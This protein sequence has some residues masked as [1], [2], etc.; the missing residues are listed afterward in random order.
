MEM[1]QI[2]ELLKKMEANRKT[3][4]EEMEAK[5]RADKEDFMARMDANMKAWQEKA[6]ADT[7]AWGEEIRSMRFETTN[8]RTET[9]ACQEVE[10]RQEEKEPSSVDMKPEVGEQREVP[11]ED[12]ELMP[13]GEPKK[14]RRRDRKLVAERRR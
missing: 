8:T 5:R 3:D 1:Q 13:V 14:K 2:M 11:V 10:A 6:D 12:A 9:M 4:K 7:K